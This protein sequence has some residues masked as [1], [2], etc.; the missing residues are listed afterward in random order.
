MLE[1]NR[2]SSISVVRKFSV[3]GE[4]ILPGQL[5]KMYRKRSGLTQ[6]Q[7]AE[8]LGIS[9]RT[10][11]LWEVNQNPPLEE[12]LTKY[13]KVALE[14]G[15]F[16]ADQE[17]EEARKL[18]EAVKDLN[19]AQ[20]ERT[21]VYAV[22]DQSNFERILD[23]RQ[24]LPL[25]KEIT[26]KIQKVSNNLPA[27]L[28]SFIGREREIT[29]ISEYIDKYRL[30]TLTG[31]GGVGK[32]R[33]ALEV[34]KIKLS[35]FLDGVWFVELAALRDGSLVIQN[36]AEILGVKGQVGLSM[37]ALVTQIIGS[38]QMLIILDNC[39]H[40]LEAVADLVHTLLKNC[41]NLRLIAT[42]REILNTQGEANY[43]LPILSF[44]AVPEKPLSLAE[45]IEFEAV[46]LFVERGKAAQSR[47]KLDDK[48]GAAVREICQKLNGIPLAIELAASRL[49]V[50]SVE[51]IVIGLNARFKLLI[52]GSRTALPRQQ[53]LKALIDWSYN[54]LTKSEQNLFKYLAVFA[55]GFTVEAARQICY[56][57]QGLD[58]NLQDELFALVDKNLLQLVE[59]RQGDLRFKMLE[60]I[61]EYALELLKASEEADN[62]FNHYALY[63]L[64][65]AEEAD[66][67]L[68]GSDQEVWV[69]TLETEQDNLRAALSLSL[70]QNDLETNLRLSSSLGW[71]W[72]IKGYLNEG[73]K[74]LESGLA[75]INDNTTIPIKIL[76]KANY[77]NGVLRQFQG[78][79]EFA[80]YLFEKSLALYQKLNDKEGVANSYNNLGNIAYYQGDH[81]RVKTMYE[82]SLALRRTLGDKRSIADSLNNLGSLAG[83]LGEFDRASAL[84][85][86]SLALRRELG[87]KQGI[88]D[89]VNNVGA[90]AHM[91]KDYEKAKQLYEESLILRR[92]I[93][94]KRGIG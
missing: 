68:K 22:F 59:N 6:K 71:F 93:G 34:A 90:I 45:L 25:Q 13:L 12:Y 17:I 11:S 27:S 66:P 89:S 28:T 30:V 72:Y 50:L 54:L 56:T 49:R 69:I 38:K 36:L 63:Y 76:A 31:T 9:N 77:A 2:S 7:L 52:G 73:E 65:L 40:L 15:F 86:E 19:D 67:K 92:Q 88:A 4:R 37:I 57:G 23:E 78:N 3:T 91:L 87:N 85:E 42:S 1:N 82:K 10:I 80:T 44:P 21:K 24:S 60:T 35:D 51:Q 33:L 70:G 55:G 43:S 26:A 58:S 14:H 84:F 79:Y 81:A 61:Q 83:T 32:T 5:F 46:Q 41:G 20:F 64:A 94:N 16:L 47:F 48:N 74:W 8:K 53:T 29:E 75:K 39:E 18:W 62:L